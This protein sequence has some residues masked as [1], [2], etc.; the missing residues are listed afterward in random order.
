[1]G[2]FDKLRELFNG[3]ENYQPA[4]MQAQN[5][6]YEK[7]QLCEQIVDLVRRISMKDTLNTKIRSLQN[8]SVSRLQMKDFDE[9]N[10]L[11]SSLTNELNMIDQRAQR[12]NS[13]SEELEASRWTGNK[14]RG[15]TDHDFDWG[16]R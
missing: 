15:Q 4:Q 11:H 3:N 12:R 9:L 5:N 8:I 6:D 2:I 10:R 16:Q 14:Q 1:M 13:Q 7:M